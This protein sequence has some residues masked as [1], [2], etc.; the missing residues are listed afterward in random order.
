M[1]SSAN[2]RQ[3]T[4]IFATLLLATSMIL[5]LLVALTQHQ[6][7]HAAPTAT[8]VSGPIITHTTWTVAGSPYI[9]TDIVIVNPGITLTIEPGVTVMGQQDYI[10]LRVRG[11]L[12]AIGTPANPITF[13][14]ELDSAPG[15][16]AA[17]AFDFP[18][19]T[20]SG[21]L[22]N[23]TLRYGTVGLVVFNSLSAD[24]VIIE[25]STIR[26]NGGYAIEASANAIHNLQMSNVV[27][28]NNG[29]DRV[30]IYME[31]PSNDMLIADTTLTAQPGLEG[32]EV[33]SAGSGGG[34]LIVPIGITLTL[35]P[36]VMFMMPEDSRLLVGG[37]L[38]AIGTVPAP[39]TFTSALN[40][41]P[42]QW[43]VLGIGGNGATGSAHLNHVTIRYLAHG[44][45]VHNH[46]SNGLV[47]IENSMIRD[48]LDYVIQANTHTIHHL[49]MTNVTFLDNEYDQIIFG[50]GW[51]SQ[52]LITN[53]ALP[54]EFPE[55]RLK[56]IRNKNYEDELPEFKTYLSLVDLLSDDKLSNYTKYKK[57]CLTI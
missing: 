4:I 48:N 27:F 2:T 9:M 35:K 43:D 1:N 18:A 6:P 51:P 31:D 19:S 29:V 13:T 52:N 20:G 34:D 16:W 8:Y 22:A 41:G 45:G 3:P 47:R 23:V 38:E 24:P 11:H 5:A 54:V 44:I 17:L 56:E 55:E 30:H 21:H 12:Q 26:D 49:V 15:Q 33:Y 36:G 40:T 7:A 37:Y 42:G 50:S 25:N 53:T 46:L 32:Y 10:G 14:S 28:G 57:M 39:I